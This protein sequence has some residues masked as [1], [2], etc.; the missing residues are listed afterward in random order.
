MNGISSSQSSTTYT[1]FG[2]A[3]MDIDPS[4]IENISVLKGA[5][6]SALYGSRAAN[7]VVLITTK[8]GTGR[9][10]IGVEFSTSAAWANV[11]VLPNYQNEYGQGRNGSE[12]EW[13]NNYSDL[14]YQEFHD[15]REFAWATDGVSGNR[16]DWDESWGSRL[17]AGLMVPQFDSPVDADGNVTA[18]PSFRFPYPE[19]EVT[20]NG[21]NIPADVVMNDLYWGTQVWWDTRTGVQ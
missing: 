21:A 12:Y 11:Y 16:L 17:D 6:A 18:T 15:Q 2:N 9:Q 1:D 5:S 19:S 3:A 4:N 14:S 20:S 13:Q 7:G 10:G 8:K